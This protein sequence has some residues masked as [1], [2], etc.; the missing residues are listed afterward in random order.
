MAR[1]ATTRNAQMDAKILNKDIGNAVEGV[2]RH[3][4]ELDTLCCGTLGSIEF[5]CEAARS[6]HREDLRDIAAKRLMAVLKEAAISGDYRWNSGKSQFNLGLFRR[7]LWRWL[8]PMSSRFAAEHLDLAQ[9]TAPKLTAPLARYLSLCRDA[10]GGE[11]SL[12]HIE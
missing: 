2:Q 11:L 10:R 7:P 6:L 12:E 1:L 9:A 8:Y 4:S 3:S 5:F